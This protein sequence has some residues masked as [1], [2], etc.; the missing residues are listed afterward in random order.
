MSKIIN[1]QDCDQVVDQNHEPLG[2]IRTELYIHM[3]T[4]YLQ[5]GLIIVTWSYMQDKI[6]ASH[7]YFGGHMDVNY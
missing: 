2:L 3:Y 7:T 4:D 6:F 1:D 5:C